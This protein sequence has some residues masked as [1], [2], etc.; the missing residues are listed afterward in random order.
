M[1]NIIIDRDELPLA[2][3]SM[4]PLRI[5]EGI[6]DF[7]STDPLLKGEDVEEIRIKRNG[8][9]WISASLENYFVGMHVKSREFDEILV[10]ACDGSL[11]AYASTIKNGYIPIG[12][13][14]RLGVSGA[15]GGDGVKRIDTLS[16][17][18]PHK[19]RFPDIDFKAL[20]RE[21]SGGEGILIFSKPLG[22]KT[23]ALRG[24]IRAL[25]SGEDPVRVVAVDSRGELE[26]DSSP[27]WCVDF[28]SHY[29][30]REGIEIAIRTL[31][32]QA[33]VCDEIGGGEVGAICELHGGGVPL[34]ASAHAGSISDLLMREGMDELHRRGVFGIYIELKRGEGDGFIIRRRRELL[35]P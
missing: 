21:L 33:V 28:L 8:G 20:Y 19:N 1:E 22:G 9:I 7:L 34:L 18:I 5:K 17:R 23:T 35:D 6:I 30:K 26:Y 2:V 11:Y 31:G 10:G 29:P 27:D 4:L 32:A 14:I 15:W 3:C 16:F 13:G 24:A 12:N 25:S